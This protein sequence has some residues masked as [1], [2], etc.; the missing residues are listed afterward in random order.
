MDFTQGGLSW[1][2]KKGCSEIEYPNEEQIEKFTQALHDE[3]EGYI[4]DKDL[5]AA[6]TVANSK[7]ANAVPHKHEGFSYS[8]LRFP[9]LI[10]VF[11][12]IF[13]E[14]FLYF[15]LRQIV[16]TWEYF[17]S[18]RGEKRKLRECLRNAKTFEEWKEAAK[19]LDTYLKKDDWKEQTPYHYYDYKLITK[20]SIRL[21]K[22]REKGD[23]QQLR[24][25]LL[26]GA[27]KSNVGGCENVRLYSNTYYGT[28]KV[29]EDFLDEVAQSLAFIAENE[30]IPLDEKRHFFKIASKNYG[31]TALCL[32]GGASFGYYHFGVIKA[33]AENDLLPRVITGTSAGSLIAAMVGCR[34]NEEL[35]DI[36]RPE[37][38][39]LLNAC[40]GGYSKMALNFLLTGS[41]FDAGDWAHKVQWITKGCMTFLEAYKRTGRILNIT[42]VPMGTQAPPKLLNYI[43]APDCVIWTAVIASSA[44]P[45]ILK[46]VVLLRKT[47]EGKIEPF[48]NSGHRWRDGSLRTDIPLDSLHHFFN[49]RY[50][51]VSQVNPHI[52]LFFYNNKGSVGRPTSHRSGK[53]WRGGFVASTLEQYIKLDLKKWLRVLRDLELMP[54]VMNQ[55]WSFIWLQK[56]E[57][58]V[59]ILPKSTFMDYLYILRD[60]DH[61]RMVNYISQGQRNTW[62]KL[63]MIENRMRIERIIEQTRDR[64]KVEK[65]RSPGVDPNQYEALAA[66]G[67]HSGSEGDAAAGE[68]REAVEY[69]EDNQVFKWQQDTTETHTETSDDDSD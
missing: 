48:M 50:A 59:T 10:F 5:Y 42:V 27:V 36:I 56:F 66:D 58:N 21:K 47:K 45:G 44:I 43:T 28:K 61:Q 63:H 11:S 7:A 52:T 29:V 2:Q 14:L 22:L 8:L 68:I 60:P 62:P 67:S 24:E 1:A 25:L 53:G 12:I 55:D 31:R 34:T 49:V 37:I 54:N 33:L 64:I 35:V 41:C 16:N 32:S 51:V 3:A 65:F 9:L 18:W 6:P 15:L 39:E 46:P 40:A 13:F 19:A 57:G 20:L 26:Q 69:I 30:S 4:S 38:C 17:Y 23:E